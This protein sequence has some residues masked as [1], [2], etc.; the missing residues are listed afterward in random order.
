MGVVA[1]S[2]ISLSIYLSDPFGIQTWQT[3]ALP[4]T[5]ALLRKNPSNEGFSSKPCLI[6]AGYAFPR[7]VTGLST[8]LG[9]CGSTS[10]AAT[11]TGLG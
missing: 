1:C 7:D 3:E 11:V 8:I 4:K 6:P 2:S 10:A 5:T 9:P